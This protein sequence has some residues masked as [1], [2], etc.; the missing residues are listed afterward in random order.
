MFSETLKQ[1][2][3]AIPVALIA[4]AL[5]LSIAV[6]SAHAGEN[7]YCSLIQTVSC[8][9]NLFKG[10]KLII[11]SHGGISSTVYIVNPFDAT[12]VARLGLGEQAADIP[13]VAS[14][15]ITYYVYDY[16]TDMSVE[17]Q[18]SSKEPTLLRVSVIRNE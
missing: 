3:K 16:G 7:N 10:D 9:A 6:P 17:N 2:C 5:M 12:A 15:S 18:S 1:W 13:L 14:S 8:E 11:E 4:V